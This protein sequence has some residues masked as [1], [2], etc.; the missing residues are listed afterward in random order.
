MSDAWLCAVWPDTRSRSR[1]LESW[2]LGHFQRL[3]PPSITIVYPGEG[4]SH[5]SRHLSVPLFLFSRLRRLPLG[6]SVAFE[7][8]PH[9][10]L[11]A[12]PPGKRVIGSC[13]AC[14]R[15]RKAIAQSS[16]RDPCR[17]SRSGHFAPFS[18]FLHIK[19]RNLPDFLFISAYDP[20]EACNVLWK[21]VRTFLRNPEHTDTQARQLYLYRWG[22]ANDRTFLN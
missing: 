18:Q 7:T 1:A 4:R 9:R 3:S 11:W 17:L 15:A 12:T 14:R 21:S 13:E 19:G 22:L 20:Y 16:V 5:T 2:I 6:T 8:V 10:R